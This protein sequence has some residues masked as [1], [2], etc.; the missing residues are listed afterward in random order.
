MNTYLKIDAELPAGLDYLNLNEISLPQTMIN[1]GSLISA[2]N[3]TGGITQDIINQSSKVIG[4]VKRTTE[5]GVLLGTKGYI[6]TNLEELS[7]FTVIAVIKP[8]KMTNDLVISTFTHESLSQN[9]QALGIGLAPTRI[10]ARQESGNFSTQNLKPTPIKDTFAIV[11]MSRNGDQ[12]I[13]CSRVNK[14]SGII[15]GNCTNEVQK[16]T[17]FGIGYT[18]NANIVSSD[19]HSL[20]LYTAIHSKSLTAIDLKKYVDDLASEINLSI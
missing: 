18:V 9:G 4:E 15:T 17:A 1:I 20:F 2:F 3:F 14:I 7:E 11:A 13:G 16:K 8:I 19:Y 10:H 6:N 12:L 5:Q